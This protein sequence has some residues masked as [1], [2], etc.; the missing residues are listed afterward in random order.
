MDVTRNLQITQSPVVVVGLG[1]VGLTLSVFLANK[2]VDVLGVESD[3]SLNSKII[4]GKSPFFEKDFDAELRRVIHNGKLQ[5]FE[6]IPQVVNAS[7]FIVCVGSKLEEIRNIR[8]KIT[9]IISS[10]EDSNTSKKYVFLRSTVPVGTTFLIQSATKD[11]SKTRVIFCPERTIEG[12]ALRE[13][14]SLPQ[15]IGG[16]LEGDSEIAESFFQS[17]GIETVRLKSSAHAEFAKLISNTFRD[18]TFGIS[19]EFAFLAEAQDLDY[20]HIREAA[21]KGYE[22]MAHLPAPGPSSGPCLRKDGLILMSQADLGKISLIAAAQDRNSLIFKWI[23]KKINI[24]NNEKL[25]KKIAILGASFKGRPVTSDTR[26]SFANTIADELNRELPSCRVEIFDTHLLNS[27]PFP[28]T[29]Y[30]RLEEC[31]KSSDLVV[32]QNNDPFFGS[33][34]F[35]LL[36]EKYQVQVLDLWNQVTYYKKVCTWGGGT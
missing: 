30:E 19:N 3:V 2:G 5:V 32:L 33:Q 11:S 10:I 16:D 7:L 25:I 35:I 23:L 8:E 20:I 27:N 28:K 21:A 36:L 22:R 13:L 1:Y 6:S 24:V 14:Q 29:L 17:V 9:A 26:D 12:A 18:V 31:I 34:N 4:Q 15:L